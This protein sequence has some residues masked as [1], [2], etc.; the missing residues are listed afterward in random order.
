M[1]ELSY[2]TY[3]STASRRAR[4]KGLN[5]RYLGQPYFDLKWKLNFQVLQRRP[6]EV[7][8]FYPILVDQIL[9]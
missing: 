6:A 8:L 2:S 5:A 4:A 1:I 9:C 3:D 7:R